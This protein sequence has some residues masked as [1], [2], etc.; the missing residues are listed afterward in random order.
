MHGLFRSILIPSLFCLSFNSFA[1]KAPS[2]SWTFT[3]R[4]EN[5]LFAQTDQYYTNGIKLNWISPDLDWFRELPWLKK[6]EAVQNGID[7][8][9]KQLP[10]SEDTSRQRHVSLS[11][12]QLL[13]TPADIKS[14][15]LIPDDRPYAGWLYGSAAF[16]SKTFFRLDTFE[17]LAGFTGKWSLGEETQNFVHSLR[18]IDTAK[19]WDNQLNTEFDF[20]FI[21]DHKHRYIPHLPFGDHWGVDV[22]TNY[23]AALGTAFTHA[24]AGFEVRAGWNLPADFGT[25]LIRPAGD[26][27]APA[28]RKDPRYQ[29]KF[30]SLSFHVFAA[31]T[32][33][34]VIRDLF[35]DGNTFS[36][37]HSVEKEN[38]V[39][40]FAVGAS[41]SYRRV[42]LS[43]AHVLRTRE[44]RGQPR[45]QQFGSISLSYTY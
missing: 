23:G 42:K 34:L 24:S 31:A 30:R 25:A 13:Y 36:D 7:R 3:L 4:F 19:G 35:L 15:D 6:D 17:I 29:D 39:G 40:D 26:T 14:R 27:S 12:G 28:N 16:H 44:F 32:G 18:G 11:V 2:N 8:I 41:I 20:S 1:D 9:L 21:Y 10:Y 45:V 33:R 22:I 37:S 43:Y 5:D 38:L